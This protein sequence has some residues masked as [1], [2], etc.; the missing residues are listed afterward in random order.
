MSYI[1]DRIAVLAAVLFAVLLVISLGWLSPDGQ[2][3][4]DARMMGYDVEAAR[5]YLAT[6]PESSRAIYLGVF[7]WID[8]VFP[9]L[10]GIA[11]GGFTWQ[12]AVRLRPARRVGFLGLT[13][14]YVLMDLTENAQVAQMLRS[15]GP[16][17]KT[18]VFKNFLLLIL[19]QLNAN[20]Y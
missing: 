18:L 2:S 11:I 3:N 17:A 5:S 19:V 7:R 4:F 6:L 12:A 14:G 16:V 15:D 9:I 10:A 20:D 1:L 13:G 8:T